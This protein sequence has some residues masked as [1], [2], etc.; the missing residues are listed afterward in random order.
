M[1]PECYGEILWSA[2]KLKCFIC[3]NKARYYI[4]YRGF[5]NEVVERRYC[6][7]HFKK[8]LSF[9]NGRR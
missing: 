2:L 7:T 3:R 8:A 1:K 9:L 5:A 4:E 6:K